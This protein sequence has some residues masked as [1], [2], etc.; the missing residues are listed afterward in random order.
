MKINN[1]K[2]S[3]LMHAK[4]LIIR[5]ALNNKLSYVEMEN[6]ILL[7]DNALI[8]LKND[9]ILKKEYKRRKYDKSS[10]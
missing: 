5:I 2:T 1:Y 4:N 6:E 9:R 7:G 3:N 8:R 10:N